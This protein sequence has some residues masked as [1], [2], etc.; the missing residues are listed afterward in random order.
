MTRD[1]WAEALGVHELAK[2]NRERIVIAR[3][4]G[5]K[6]GLLDASRSYLVTGIA[7]F[8]I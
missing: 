4:F 7:S 2:M 1:F 3:I 6:A 5:K 8:G